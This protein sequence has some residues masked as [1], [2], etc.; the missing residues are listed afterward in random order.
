MTEL[1]LEVVRLRC[2]I[3]ALQLVVRLLYSGLANSSP[4]DAQVFRVQFADGKGCGRCV[5]RHG[6]HSHSQDRQYGEDV[7]RMSYATELE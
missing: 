2:Q 3:L 6:H 1:E 4:A 5:R 7:S